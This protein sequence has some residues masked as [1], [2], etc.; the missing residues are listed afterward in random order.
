MNI[1]PARPEWM[2]RCVRPNTWID[3]RKSSANFIPASCSGVRV[4]DAAGFFSLAIGLLSRATADH[5]TMIR[6]LQLPSRT[7]KFAGPVALSD[8]RWGQQT[9]EVLL[10]SR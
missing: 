8:R 6:R 1:S 4:P 5:R 10:L 7:V 2:W 9:G 3:C